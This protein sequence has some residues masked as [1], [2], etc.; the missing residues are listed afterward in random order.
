MK[1]KINNRVVFL[2]IFIC[3]IAL[4]VVSKI[5]IIQKI[6]QEVS[7]V[8]IP[9]LIKIKAPRGNIFSDDG[10]LLAISMPLYNIYMD[11][12]VVE[13]NTFNLEVESLSISLSRLF[14]DKSS[15]EYEKYLLLMLSFLYKVLHHFHR[16]SYLLL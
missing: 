11:L 6:D 4:I 2:Y 13:K 10:S 1:N 5:L 14:N 7:S 3:V 9:K 15:Q 16:M 12:S 8:N